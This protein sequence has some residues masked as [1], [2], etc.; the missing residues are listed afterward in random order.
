MCRF[1]LLGGAA[2]RAARRSLPAEA[3][4]SEAIT[5]SAVPNPRTTTG[6]TIGL[7]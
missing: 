6:G 5:A 7:C 3:A 4:R 1:A 2:G